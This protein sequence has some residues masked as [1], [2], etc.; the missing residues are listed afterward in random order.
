V[1]FTGKVE[2]LSKAEMINE[3]QE[4]NVKDDNLDLKVDKLDLMVDKLDLTVDR[5]DLTVDDSPLKVDDS[6]LKVDDS[7][8]KVDDSLL[9]V[10]QDKTVTK[11]QENE[12]YN[13]IKLN[14][15]EIHQIKESIENLRSSP[16]EMKPIESIGPVF[17][18]R[19]PPPSHLLVKFTFWFNCRILWV[20][21]QCYRHLKKQVQRV[22]L[23]VV[24]QL[25]HRNHQERKSI[26]IVLL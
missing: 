12:N 24:L 9:K 18:S 4:N 10:Q 26:L 17:K 2:D 8:L 21:S 19:I 14:N 23:E 20:L 13:T 11:D 7:L 25:V 1:L 6:L 3:I 15:L 16:I 5:L 22:H